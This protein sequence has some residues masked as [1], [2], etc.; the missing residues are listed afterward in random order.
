MNRLRAPIREAMDSFEVGF[1]VDLGV[2]IAADFQGDPGE[3]DVVVA[4]EKTLKLGAIGER[5]G[6]NA[7][8]LRMING[9]AAAT[10]TSCSRSALSFN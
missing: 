8:S 3:I 2:G 1:N 7:F 5:C 6:Q 4:G 10:T 9:A